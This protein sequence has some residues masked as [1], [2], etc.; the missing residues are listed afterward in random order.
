MGFLF[1]A[2]IVFQY[3]EHPY[4]I[5]LTSLFSTANLPVLGKSSN[6]QNGDS[7]S[8]S[9]FAGNMSLPNDSN[10]TGTDAILDIANSTRTSNFVSEG[11]GGGSN[12][13]LELDVGNNDFEESS[14]VNPENQNKTSIPDDVKNVDNKFSPEEGSE[15][16]QDSN[17]NINSTYNNSSMGGIGKEGDMVVSDHVG[18]SASDLASSPSVIAPINSSEY[19]P[20]I[21][22]D[23][24]I[25]PPTVSGSSNTSL[26]EKDRTTSSEEH[27]ESERLPS[28]LNQTQNASSSVDR[29]PEVKKQPEVPILAVYPISEMNNLLLQS[30]SSYYSVV[31][32]CETWALRYSE[33]AKV[34]NQ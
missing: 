17:R 7:P 13:S 12:S 6:L 4:G 16:E 22:V 9:E 11:N 29:V 14:S 2:V 27:E 24:S 30:R 20:P 25:V 26:V 34:F 31:Y 32:M 15:P 21:A 3:F 10:H 5:A 1:A 8:N 18:S 19:T 28:D 33:D 23:T